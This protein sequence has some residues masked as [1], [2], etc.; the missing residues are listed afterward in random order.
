[1]NIKEKYK[2]YLAK[3][4]K[5]GIA[6]DILFVVFL[7]ALLIPQSRM[8]VMAFVNKAKMLVMQPSV[9]AADEVVSIADTDYQM[10]F[11]DLNGQN[12]DFSTAK[13]KVIFLNFWGTWCPP[14]VAEM[15]SIQE[16]YNLYKDNPN[17]AFLM[18]STEESD[19]VKKFINKKGYNFPVYIN[20]YKL[21]EAFTFSAFPTTFII[22]KSGKIVIRE[23]GAV[24]WAGKNMK[25]TL[26][27]LIIE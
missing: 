27:K 3:K 17:V 18:V 10:T 23:V 26:D 5:F 14:C 7:I 20:H 11:T 25:E 9:K 12:F 13:G 19:V 1:M 8:E 15:P 22:S 24:N 21:P 2:Q 16:L 4:S 6:T